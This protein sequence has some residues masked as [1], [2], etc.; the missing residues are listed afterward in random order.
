MLSS[1]VCASL[2]FFIKIALKMSVFVQLILIIYLFKKFA[3]SRQKL[4]CWGNPESHYFDKFSLNFYLSKFQTPWLTTL[5]WCREPCQ[6]H[7]TWN[8][9]NLLHRQPFEPM[10][11]FRAVVNIFKLLL[12]WH[13]G[14][15]TTCNNS[16]PLKW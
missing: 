10:L 3:C 2:A 15:K 6:T 9:A 1:E 12:I 4:F 5:A 7:E 11:Y 8:S 16:F 14:E 13:P